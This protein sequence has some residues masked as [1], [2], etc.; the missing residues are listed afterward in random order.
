MKKITSIVALM[1]AVL[2]SS[3]L[4]AQKINVGVNAAGA[5]PVGDFGNLT[6]F[7]FGGDVSLDYYFNDKFDVGIE[8]GYRAFPYDDALASGEN[9][10]LIPIQLT[11]AYHMDIDDWIDLYGELGG[12]LFLASSS[13]AGSETEAYGGIS[14]RI[15][16]AF[17]LT[18]EWFLDVNVNYG[19]VFSEDT[20]PAT[21]NP[22]FNWVGINVGILYTILD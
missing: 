14:P 9:I 5:I 19:M 11:A 2:L 4:Y 7:G 15:G 10:N 21:F 1:S 6:T 18:P 3:G 8:A 12:G 20:S 13:I 16:A 17:E 22:N